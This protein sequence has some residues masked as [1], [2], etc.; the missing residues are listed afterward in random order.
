MMSGC[1]DHSAIWSR[2]KIW[3]RNCSSVVWAS[4]IRSGRVGVRS[5]CGHRSVVHPCRARS[6]PTAVERVER[7]RRGPGRRSTTHSSSVCCPPARGP[8]VIAG[9]PASAQKLLPSSHERLGARSAAAGRRSPRR[10]CWKSATNGIALV[11]QEG[12]AD[13]AA[14]RR[15][16]VVPVSR[17]SSSSSCA[18]LALD[19]GAVGPRQPAARAFEPALLRILVEDLAAVDLADEDARRPGQRIGVL[20]RAR[21]SQAPQP[22]DQLGAGGDDARLVA[23]RIT[24]WTGGP[25]RRIVDLPGQA[26]AADDRQHVVRAARGAA[27]RRRRSRR[28]I[29]RSSCRPSPQGASCRSWAVS[30]IAAGRQGVRRRAGR[31]APRPRRPMPAFHVGGAAAAEPVALDARRHERQVDGVEVAVELQR[32]ARLLP[33]PADRDGRRLGIA[34]VGPLDGEAVGRAGCPPGNRGRPW[35]RRSGSAPRRA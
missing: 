12:V 3:R 15:S 9:T 35:L 32:P 2:T 1:F 4:A 33:L 23:G 28:A 21:S 31:A 30:R 27:R 10:R 7:G 6:R 13:R 24:S 25:G 11:E 34:A 8:C 22:R 29:S 17:A 19:V 5:S 16:I 20:R 18:E 26:A 14:A